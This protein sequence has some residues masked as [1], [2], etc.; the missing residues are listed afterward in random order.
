MGAIMIEVFLQVPKMGEMF[1][2]ELLHVPEERKWNDSD[3]ES[4]PYFLIRD[5]TFPLKND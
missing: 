3:N 1:E 4:L 2:D 5:E